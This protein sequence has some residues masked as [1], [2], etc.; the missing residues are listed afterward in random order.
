MLVEYQPLYLGKGVGVSAV[1]LLFEVNRQPDLTF[2]PR[3]GTLH[4]NIF[5]TMSK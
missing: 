2:V 5:S 4:N 1:I 3:Y